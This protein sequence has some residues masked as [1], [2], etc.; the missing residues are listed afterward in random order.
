MHVEGKATCAVKM[1]RISIKDSRENLLNEDG[2]LRYLQKDKDFS[3]SQIIERIDLLSNRDGRIGLVLELLGMDLFKYYRSKETGLYLEETRRMTGQLATAL[4]FL[5]RNEVIHWDI[6]PQ[7][8]LMSAD[9][10]CVKVADFGS[11]TFSGSVY[12][13]PNMEGWT[14]SYRSPEVILGIEVTQAIDVWSLAAVIGEIY[15]GKVIFEPGL[16]EVK[17]IADHCIRLGSP[18]PPDLVMQGSFLGQRIFKGSS[19]CKSDAT[20]ALSKIIYT[21]SNKKAED[22]RSLMDLLHKMFIYDPEQRA[23]AEEILE[24]PFLR[25]EEVLVSDLQLPPMGMSGGSHSSSSK[26]QHRTGSMLCKEGKLDPV[27]DG[28]SSSDRRLGSGGFGDVFELHFEGKQTYA[29][30]LTKNAFEGKKE[31]LNEDGILRYLQKDQNFSVSHIIE[32][33]DLLPHSDG[34]IGLVLELLGMNLASHY[35]AKE[36]GLPLEETRRITGQL[37]T[38]LSFLCRNEVIHW[39][40][41]PQNIL[42]SADGTSVKLADFGSAAFFGPVYNPPNIE[43]Q[44]FFYRSPEVILGIQATAAIDVWSLAV[45]ISE[46]YSNKVLFD[47]SLDEAELIAYHRFRLE[48][49][50]PTSLVKEATILGKEIFNGAVLR[51]EKLRIVQTFSRI[52]QRASAQKGENSSQ[53]IHLLNTMFVYDPKKRATPNEILNHPFFLQGEVCSGHEKSPQEPT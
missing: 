22:S 4:S 15:S 30:K 20:I 16:D 5:R 7:N 26:T 45:V 39:D 1:S 31:L 19:E 3:V 33:I 24:H 44:T 51:S 12:N 21:A 6:R 53:L 35:Q 25:P 48:S 29:V 28:E 2:K 46:I 10:T 43:G 42:M 41:K 38:A 11:A 18:Y 34:R 37:A 40:I 8:I 9:G 36:R 49:P 47:A 17:L 13:P 52:I 14:F 32:R 27:I 50:Y 23:T